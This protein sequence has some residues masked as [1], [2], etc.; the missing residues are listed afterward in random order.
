MWEEVDSRSKANKTQILVHTLILVCT[1]LLLDSS[2]AISS[3]ITEKV[4]A[5][6]PNL[7][8]LKW[9]PPVRIKF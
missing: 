7:S 3:Q 9:I 8:S 1:V 2:P 6:A 4:G 5:I